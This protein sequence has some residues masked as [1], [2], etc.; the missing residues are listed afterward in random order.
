MAVALADDDVAEGLD[1]LH[2][3]ARPQRHRGGALFDAPAGNLGVLGLNRARDVGD[4]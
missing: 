4:R 1:R 3:A 2:A